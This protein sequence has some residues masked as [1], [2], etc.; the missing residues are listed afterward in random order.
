VGNPGNRVVID[1]YISR[2]PRDRQRMRVVPMK[3]QALF[4]SERKNNLSSSVTFSTTT[5]GGGGGGETSSG[6]KQVPLVGRRAISLVDT[7]A[8]DGKLAFVEVRIPTG[9]THQIRVH[10]QDRGTPVYGDDTYGLMD[11]NKK[12]SKRYYG[13][14]TTRPLLHAYQLELDHHPIL[15]SSSSLEGPIESDNN[16]S[17]SRKLIFR[18]PI[19]QDIALVTDSIWPQGRVERPDFFCPEE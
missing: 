5:E 11:W 3:Q 1:N 19:P 17:K 10:L 16:N 9:R 14:N 8:F 15:V 12:L 13:G 2:H 7:K 18:A 4:P 6:G